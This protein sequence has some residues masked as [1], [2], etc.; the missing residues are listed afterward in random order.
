MA[1]NKSVGWIRERS[2]TGH[3]GVGYG[4]RVSPSQHGRTRKLEEEKHF[5]LKIIK[6]MH[7]CGIYVNFVGHFTE[8]LSMDAD[9][10]MFDKRRHTGC[11]LSKRQKYKCRNTHSSF[12]AFNLIQI[13]TSLLT[14]TS[15]HTSAPVQTTTLSVL[16]RHM[17][18]WTGLEDSIFF[19]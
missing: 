10:D 18:V 6:I 2:A 3:E 11:R 19:A 7:F 14:S 1:V 17:V 15:M 9:D 16:H 8:M 4:E 5:L 12:V 13:S